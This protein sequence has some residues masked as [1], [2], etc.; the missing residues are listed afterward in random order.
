MSLVSVML[1]SLGGIALAND[2]SLEVSNYN[3]SSSLELIPIDDLFRCYIN[4]IDILE[5]DTLKL[6]TNSYSYIKMSET[7][8]N[9]LSYTIDEYN[10]NLGNSL[11]NAKLIDVKD[12]FSSYIYFFDELE[13]GTLKVNIGA[14][15][16]MS[17]T[18]RNNLRYTINEHN[19]SFDDLN[20]FFDSNVAVASKY[21]E[22]F[23]KYNDYIALND[24]G[25]FYLK[26]SAYNDLS[27]SEIDN[28]L[29]NLDEGNKVLL[30]QSKAWHI[31]PIVAAALGIVGVSYAGGRYAAR[32]L[33]NRGILTKYTYK[34][35]RWYYRSFIFAN[36]GPSVGFGVDDYYM[37]Y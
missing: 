31:I 18:D 3:T 2:E 32:S 9:N 6:N 15:T 19:K 17:E 16:D 20:E 12:L 34:R 30:R 35:F 5:D 26:E 36:W 33:N 37:G 11:V 29:F 7:N 22:M 4:S 27:A 10:K 1:S 25:E 23:E 24:T 28:I 21:D 8:R 14:Y 13:D